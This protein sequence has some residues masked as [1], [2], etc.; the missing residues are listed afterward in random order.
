MVPEK[1]KTASVSSCMTTVCSE[2]T[3]RLLWQMKIYLIKIL[4]IRKELEI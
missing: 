3:D 1:N 4:K 2:E